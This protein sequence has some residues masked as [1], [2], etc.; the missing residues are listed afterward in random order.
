M[1]ILHYFLGFPP[2][3]SGGLTKYAVDLMEAQS[4]DG[5]EIVGLW[6]GTMRAVS[7]KVAVKKK[8]AAGGI[9]NYEIINPLPV[10]LDEGIKEWECYTR[11]CDIAVYIRFL[12]KIQPDVIHIHTLMGLHREF[13]DAAK[14]LH[15]RI[16]FTTHD[17]FGLCP[18]VTLYKNGECC[19]NDH[20][21]R[22]CIG[23]NRSALSIH[24]IRVMQS[25]LY[26][27]LKD[28]PF[29]KRLRK[30]HRTEFYTETETVPLPAG[31]S[32]E[33]AAQYKK[34]RQFYT[35]ILNRIDFIHFNSTVS[36]Q[37]YRR[38]LTPRDSRV[39]SITHKNIK[40]Q[41]VQRVASGKKKTLLFLAPAK[42]YKGFN[43][44]RE[45]LDQLW[46]DGYRDF[47]LLVFS[48]VKA[49]APY[50]VVRENGFEHGELKDIMSSADILLAPSIWYETF[51]FTVPEALSFGVPVIVSDH[52][53]AK[54][55]IGNSGVIVKS[56]DSTALKEAVRNMTEQKQSELREN[57][58]SL[59]IKEWSDF[60]EE[61]YG[62]Y[63]ECI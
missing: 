8:K 22:D 62:I 16:V 11:P 32:G 24:K 43:V 19:D 5:H 18:K 58:K 26:R 13:V 39:I 37:V 25:P 40:K 45:A 2:Y 23:C 63:G 29:V 55:I 9:E 46:K 44:L 35:D 50:M 30:K 38:Y 52:V 21:C 12:K 14:Q 61:I 3:R 42:P 10:P 20:G 53:G 33:E 56:G 41:A 28:V 1:K 4:A 27:T 7:A 47:Q 59:K 57:I 17:Y 60:V 36:E 34:L 15:V 49:P 51:G 54:D 48:P 6:P 31:T